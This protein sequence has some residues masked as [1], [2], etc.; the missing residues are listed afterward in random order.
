MTPQRAHTDPW[1]VCK[2]ET[3]IRQHKKK[4]DVTFFQHKEDR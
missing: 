4:N 2:Q 1:G 3:S